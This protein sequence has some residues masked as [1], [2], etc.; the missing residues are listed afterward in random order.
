MEGIGFICQ[1]DPKQREKDVEKMDLKWL[2]SLEFEAIPAPR[3][4]YDIPRLTVSGKGQMTMNPAFLRRAG[5]ARCFYGEV[6][7]DGRCLTL[8]PDEGGQLRFSPMGVRMNRDLSELLSGRGIRLP[9]SY[10]LE[11]VEE[12]SLW[13]GCSA[14]LP[15]PPQV[16][17]LLP[18]SR[19]RRGK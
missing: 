16:E 15:E 18:K 5:E 11:W 1:T 7:R 14:D 2:D 12:R 13:A 17:E 6:S 8:R 9:A 3:H 10:T 4:Y 19:G